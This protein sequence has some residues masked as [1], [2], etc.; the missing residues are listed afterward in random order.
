VCLGGVQPCCVELG[1]SEQRL[2]A[3]IAGV[4]KV[5]GLGLRPASLF[6]LS[7]GKA[8]SS[9]ESVKIFTFVFL[10]VAKWVIGRN[11][12]FRICVCVAGERCG[13]GY[14][15]I[16]F[17]VC[18]SYRV[19]RR[20]CFAEAD[21]IA[22]MC[23]C[24]LTLLV[25]CYYHVCIVCLYFEAALKWISTW[26]YNFVNK[27]KCRGVGFVLFLITY[28]YCSCEVVPESKLLV[29]LSKELRYLIVADHM[30]GA[31]SCGLSSMDATY[32]SRRC[33]AMDT[34]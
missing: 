17:C 9:R 5:S 29:E 18:S 11:L 23:C 3:A 27:V 16:V 26:V 21:L 13:S 10:A 1:C 15:P 14:Q 8:K 31:C 4:W 20:L 33:V 30:V 6:A 7:S 24:L 32:R 34:K 2:C 12:C 25:P 19:P 22:F 28:A